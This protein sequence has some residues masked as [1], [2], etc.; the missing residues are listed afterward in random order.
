MGRDSGQTRF[1]R[2]KYFF[3]R[4]N[5][6]S[7]RPPRII[8]RVPIEF[9]R[10]VRRASGVK[11]YR[12]A[13]RRSFMPRNFR[14]A[15]SLIL[16]LSAIVFSPSRSY[17]VN[18]R[19]TF[20]RTSGRLP[21]EQEWERF[22]ERTRELASSGGL[23][24]LLALRQ[25][26]I[27]RSTPDPARVGWINYLVTASTLTQ[28]GQQ[29]GARFDAAVSCFE[30]DVVQ[31]ETLL[32]YL[33]DYLN[34]IASYN[35][36]ACQALRMRLATVFRVSD[37]LTYRRMA[38]ELQSGKLVVTGTQMKF[39]GVQLDGTALDWN[40]YR[41]K[42]VLVDFWATWCGPCVAELDNVRELYEKYHDAGFEV[43]GYSLDSDVNA[44][45]QFVANNKLPWQIVSRQLTE[46]TMKKEDRAYPEL[47]QYYR[48]N[49]I[50]TMY[51]V[52]REGRVVETNA[53]GARLKEIL[54]REFPE[55]KS[56]ERRPLPGGEL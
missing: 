19:V 13:G 50:P 52:D 16:L 51:V 28:A 43:V 4:Q 14:I 7:S 53:R 44:L 9:V 3:L 48:I 31:D 12:K 55:V 24:Q 6:L 15:F 49:A 1:F 8:P 37:D 29:G 41:G 35:M 11:N 36:N 27:A 25:Q 46:T 32:Q 38:E 18:G 17:G 23:G 39:E 30:R 56:A 20:V 21:L 5:L 2:D 42:V 22:R 26:E 34:I 47:T 40:A 33:G 10:N 54:E 45:R